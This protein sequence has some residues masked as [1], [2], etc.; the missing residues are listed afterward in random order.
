[1]VNSQSIHQIFSQSIHEIKDAAMANTEA[2][3]R[4]EG[5]LG[6]LVAKF[7]IIEGEK[8]QTQEMARGQYMIDEDGP[9]SSYHEHVQATTFG[10][11]EVVKETVNLDSK[12]FLFKAIHGSLWFDLSTYANVIRAAVHTIAST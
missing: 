6:H 10:S 7:N 2:I 11:E 4:L 3:A 9:S 1:M 8:L 5:Q 12:L